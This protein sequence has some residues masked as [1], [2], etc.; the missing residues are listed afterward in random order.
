MSAAIL[1]LAICVCDVRNKAGTWGTSV[2]YVMSQ[3]FFF[4]SLIKSDPA[5]LRQQQLKFDRER[6]RERERQ[7]DR[8]RDRDRERQRDRER[9][10]VIFRMNVY[11]ATIKSLQTETFH[12]I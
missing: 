12:I 3:A 7:T 8:D 2:F 4:F 5:W 10:R 9:E 1:C 6:E 11:G